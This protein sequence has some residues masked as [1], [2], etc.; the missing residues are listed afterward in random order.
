MSAPFHD[1]ISPQV[2][3]PPKALIMWGSIV[4]SRGSWLGCL[5]CGWTLEEMVF[6]LLLFISLFRLSHVLQA[7][8]KFPVYQSVVF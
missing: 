3:Y 7:T 2:A 4:F 8:F 6:F 5:P 1:C